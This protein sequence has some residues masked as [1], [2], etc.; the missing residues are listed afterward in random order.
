MLSIALGGVC[1]GISLHPGSSSQLIAS[2]AERKEELLDSLLAQVKGCVVERD[3]G[4]ISNL[5]VRENI[6]LPSEFHGVGDAERRESR[7]KELTGRLGEDGAALRTLEHG[8]PALLSVSQKRLAGFL[9]AMLM[10]PE[11][12]VF[13]SL[14]EGISRADALKL[15]EFERIFHLYFPFRHVM[16]VNF[17][18]DPLLQ[19]MVDH[20]YSM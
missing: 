2:S 1:A 13:D 18:D 20:T 4:L 8:Q 10:E 19:G 15:R 6:A 16:F 11:F 5:S 17:S 14:L 12:M 7:L 9:R 3:G